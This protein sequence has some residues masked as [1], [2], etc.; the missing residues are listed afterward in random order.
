MENLL[1]KIIKKAFDK[2]QSDLKSE[3]YDFKRSDE[4]KYDKPSTYI[5]RSEDFLYYTVPEEE[6][7]SKKKRKKYLDENN[8]YLD[9]INEAKTFF[10]TA[11]IKHKANPYIIKSLNKLYNTGNYNP[12]KAQ[13]Y[14]RN[15]RHN[16][17]YGC[18]IFVTITPRIFI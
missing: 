3:K 1:R 2:I 11:F 18:F 15:L 9:Y 10:N 12:T 5:D 8:M 13:Y 6:L 16:K 4:Y 14:I 17:H 7:K